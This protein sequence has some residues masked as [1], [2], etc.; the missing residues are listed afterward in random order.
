MFSHPLY[1]QSRILLGMLLK[2][3]EFLEKVK[4]R[5]FQVI[6]NYSW[7]RKTT[8]YKKKKS[9]SISEPKLRFWH[10]VSLWVFLKYS[11]GGDQKQHFKS[12]I[13]LECFSP[14]CKRGFQQN[15]NIDNSK[16]FLYDRRKLEKQKW[17]F[18]WFSPR[19]FRVQGKSDSFPC[20]KCHE[21]KL[22]NYSKIP[23]SIY[24]RR[25]VHKNHRKREKQACYIEQKAKYLLKKS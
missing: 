22:F 13:F 2:Y 19:F 5:H 25:V 6:L 23:G 8:F 4:G 7:G 1:I 17:N 11:R 12:E 16:S 21:G 9:L 18:S 3:Q 10:G 24:H 20:R 15:G 14:N